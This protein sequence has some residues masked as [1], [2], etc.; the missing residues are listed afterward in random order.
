[1]SYHRKH[2]ASSLQGLGGASDCGAGQVW[3]PNLVYNGL[4]P[5]QCVPAG[6]AMTPGPAASTPSIWSNIT[7]AISSIAGAYGSSQQAQAQQAAAQA[8]AANAANQGMGTGT[9][10]LIGAGLIGAVLLLRKK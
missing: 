6:S 2:N 4:P 8:A 10:L 5:G 1:M 3:D 7:G 9:V